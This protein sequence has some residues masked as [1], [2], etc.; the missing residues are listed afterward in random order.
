MWLLI[1]LSRIA[2]DSPE[3]AVPF[4]TALKTAAFDQKFPHILI[5]HFA[6][7]ALSSIAQTLPS[8]EGQNLLNTLGQLNLSPFPRAKELR[9]HVSGLYDSRPPEHPK[10]ANEFHFD[11]DFAKYELNDVARTFGLPQWQIEDSCT[12]WIR[13]W[14]RD[15]TNM[16]SD[17][18]GK[19]RFDDRSET[20]SS[21]SQPSRDRWGGCLAW[22]ALMLTIGQFL[23]TTPVLGYSHQ[24]DPWKEWMNKQVLSGPEGLWLADGTDPFPLDVNRSFKPSESG[25]DWVPTDPAILGTIAGLTADSSLDKDLV[26]EGF[27]RAADG[28]D[29]SVRSVIVTEREAMNVALTVALGPPLHRYLPH[30]DNY[31]SYNKDSV[32]TKLIQ[33][34]TTSAPDSSMQL[35]RHDPYCSSTA[36]HRSRPSDD[37]IRKFGLMPRDPFHRRWYAKTGDIIFNAGAWGSKRGRD[38]HE[39]ENAGN[40]LSCRTAFLNSLLAQ[41]K[42]QL[43]LLITAQK[44][45]EKR[46]EEGSGTFRTETLIALVSPQRGVKFVRRIPKDARAAVDSLSQYDRSIFEA[47]LVAI[48]KALTQPLPRP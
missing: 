7:R 11:Y 3:L 15:V 25:Q 16:Y 47:R 45:L 12:A 30:E 27:W 39:T 34:W 4:R 17:A 6:E 8:P 23:N 19:T 43:V 5:R 33:F 37:V 48:R 42:S 31:G 1:A 41:R 36:L 44:Y 46:R 20:W 2:V 38:Q 21:A 9:H 28:I 18:R 40:R 24:D 26:V 29:I 22:H 14:S 32:T 10:P 13:K 35:E